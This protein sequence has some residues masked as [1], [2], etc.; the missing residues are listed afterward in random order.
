MSGRDFNELDGQKG[1]EPVAI[2]SETLAKRMFPNQDALIGMFIGRIPCCNSLPEL[3][4]R[5]TASSASPP[6]LTTNMSFQS[7]S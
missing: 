6:I 5:R 4:P 2:V 3:T 7:P 1:K